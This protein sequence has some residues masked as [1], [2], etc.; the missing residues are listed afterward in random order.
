MNQ[1]LDIWEDELLR[2]FR[3]NKF[4]SLK[5]AEK[6]VF[7]FDGSLTV[8]Q[9]LSR[10][11]NLL[12]D[13]GIRDEDTMVGYLWEGLEPNLALA[14]P[15]REDGDTLE[16]FGRRV[17]M[18]EV[19]ARRLHDLST[20]TR[21]RG[22]DAQEPRKPRFSDQKPR[23]QDNKKPSVSA[24]KAER[25]IKKLSTVTNA[26]LKPEPSN[27]KDDKVTKTL[28]RPCRHCQG[29]HWDNECPDKQKNEKKVLFL[30]EED[31]HSSVSSLNDDD[32]QVLE[33]VA[34]DHESEN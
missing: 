6:L 19:A 22:F 2:E 17:R 18:N 33:N 9:Y 20:K 12:H 7:R 5:K 23:Y 32:L 14:T 31:D 4:A 24:E 30:E 28:K 11:T 29:P 27:S 3:P 13:A 15:M 10:K 26:T 21:T 1:D 8:S 25:L 16:S 34:S